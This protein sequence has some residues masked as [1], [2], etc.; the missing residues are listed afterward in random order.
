[1]LS[2][3]EEKSPLRIFLRLFAAKLLRNEDYKMTKSYKEKVIQLGKY[4]NGNS[5]FSIPLVKCI[6]ECFEI[7]A[8]EDIV[9]KLLMVQNNSY[10]KEEL[11]RL[12]KLDDKGFNKVFNEIMDKSFMWQRKEPGKYEL[13]P[14]F[15]GWIEMYCSGPE[16]ETRKKLLKKFGEFEDL[17]KFLNIP[18]VRAYMNNVN[19]KYMQNESGRMSTAV[20]R[21]SKKV[22][23]NKK[24]TA[25]QTVYI[26]G[27]IYQML[28]KHKG[29]IAVMN[30]FCRMKKEMEGHTCDYHMP[31]EGCMAVGRMAD[32]LVEANIARMLDFEEAVN[33]IKEFEDKGSIHTIYHYGISSDEEEVIICNCCVDCCFL[34]NSYNEGALSQLL[35]KAYFK[36][37]I[38]DESKC[39]GCNLCN[40]YCPTDA[41]WYDKDNKKL[42]FD[43]N[44]CIGCGQ[45]VTQC[46]FE[47]R[48]MVRDER[49]VFVKTKR[50][51]DIVKSTR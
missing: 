8:S 27:E 46:H 23:I 35:M 32:Q 17:L 31:I 41:T 21:G 16:S 29:H 7:A 42:M 34:Y 13:T 4:M 44:K 36:P 33:L 3:A 10:S 40:R 37:E 22:E 1:M 2:D 9:D 50:K 30:C 19:T 25:E 6:Q 39:V 12:W 20:A 51:K 11:Q 45:C 28:E 26:A 14:I 43:I 5:K 15:P 48:H 49:N 18:P 47:V 24:L 38:T